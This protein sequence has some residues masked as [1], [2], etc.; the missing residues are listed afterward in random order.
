MKTTHDDPTEIADYLIEQHG[1]DGALLVAMQNAASATDNYDL[2]VWR[3]VKAILKNKKPD[4]KSGEFNREAVRGSALGGAP[5]GERGVPSDI[6]H[7][8][9]FG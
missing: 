7:K 5:E 1:P 9:I 3:E 4:P 6:V 8:S 2:S